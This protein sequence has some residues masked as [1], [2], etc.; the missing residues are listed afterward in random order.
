MW[1]LACTEYSIYGFSIEDSDVDLYQ[2]W[3]V[4]P[5][6]LPNYPWEIERLS[7][8]QR[9]LK[10]QLTRATTACSPTLRKVVLTGYCGQS[11]PYLKFPVTDWVRCDKQLPAHQRLGLL[12]PLD[13]LMILADEGLETGTSVRNQTKMPPLGKEF[14]LSRTRRIMREKFRK[15]DEEE[16]WAV[17][18]DAWR[19]WLDRPLK[20]CSWP[21]KDCSR[22]LKD[23]CRPV[24]FVTSVQQITGTVV[25]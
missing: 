7:R 5:S 17:F 19:M 1:S 9:I 10:E 6:R 3:L 24:K 15:L 4:K 22:L 13:K 11:P 12:Q 20:D 2:G 14:W 16:P 8:S 21:L 23:Y 18:F 25:F